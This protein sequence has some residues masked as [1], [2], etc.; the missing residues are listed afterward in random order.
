MSNGED[1]DRGKSAGE[2]AQRLKE[3]DQHF[4]RI[5]GSMQEVAEALN[6]VKMTMQRMADAMDADRATV[7]TTATALEKQREGTARAVEQT[8]IETRDRQERRWSPLARLSLII[9]IVVGVVTIIVT[10][11]AANGVI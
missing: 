8:R 4:D 7:I 10:V 2:I 1:F 3:H 5:N 11:L 9:G 6:G